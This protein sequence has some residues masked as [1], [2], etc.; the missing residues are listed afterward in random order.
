MLLLTITGC[1]RK[2]GYGVML[3]TPDKEY[4]N[5]GDLVTVYEKSS[6]RSTYLISPSENKKDKREVDLW[7]VRLF[8]KETDA[9]QFRADYADYVNSYARCEKT[10]L[11]MRD[12]PET[13]GERV[14][15]LAE[16][17]SMK[18]LSKASDKI[19]VGNLEGTW[20]LVLTNDGIEGYCFDY[21]LLMYTLDEKGEP[22]YEQ[23]QKQ[24]KPTLES[25]FS[26][27]WRPKFY[28]ENYNLKQVNINTFKADYRLDFD[29]D[30][31]M[32][33]YKGLKNKFQRSYTSVIEVG[34]NKYSF[35]GADFWVTFY[36]GGFISIQYALD[37]KDIA[38]TWVNLSRSPDEIIN[39]EY[40][41]RKSLYE[42][43]QNN[44][45]TAKSD[46]FGT[47]KFTGDNNFEWTNKNRLIASKVISPSAGSSGTVSFDYFPD[48]TIMD[49][50]QGGMAFRFA[51]GEKAVFLFRL[52]GGTLYL[53]W[54]NPKNID[55]DIIKSD[56][57]VDGVEIT[58]SPGSGG[59][60]QQD[61]ESDNQ[62]Q[63]PAGDDNGSQNTGTGQ[64]DN[65][66]DN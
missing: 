37:G 65:S 27:I 16:G 34:F 40:A 30:S 35:E 53:K 24:A 47:L 25:L 5:N 22:V 60:S 20:Y 42:T 44:F 51:S 54:V 23:K 19:Q 58:F 3:W 63:P 21:S 50:Y 1:G 9:V 15:K 33:N 13:S 56:F 6:L 66:G 28:E 46:R 29:N 43:L 45:S 26:T 39:E 38:E 52:E 31:K 59:G 49:R 10:G 36:E 64:T 48:E 57:T 14:Y 41:R 8:E 7:R 17:Q 4:V 2:L 12:K 61:S 11:P 55:R 62:T 32:V 18:I